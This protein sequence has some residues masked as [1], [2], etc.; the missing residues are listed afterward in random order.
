M[1]SD[2]LDYECEY[3]AEYFTDYRFFD[4]G[5]SFYFSDS[6]QSTY[7]YG[8]GCTC[9]FRDYDTGTWIDEKDI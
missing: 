2:T 1:R 4:D 6:Q 8:L 5:A 9:L 3:S 7:R